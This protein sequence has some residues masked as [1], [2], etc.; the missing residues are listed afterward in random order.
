MRG[1]KF[2]AVSRAWVRVCGK[3]QLCM[4]EGNGQGT[5]VMV[6]E[7]RR[8]RLM[9]EAAPGARRQRCGGEGWSAGA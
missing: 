2:T 8:S 1:S 4:E 7:I 5:V 6:I 9:E 3:A